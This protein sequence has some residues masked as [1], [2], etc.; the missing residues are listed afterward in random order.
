MQTVFLLANDDYGKQPARFVS[1][2]SFVSE[3]RK[4]VLFSDIYWTGGQITHSSVNTV[5]KI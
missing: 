4:M 1:A 2:G 5:Y 3:P